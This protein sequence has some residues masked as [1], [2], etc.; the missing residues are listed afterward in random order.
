MIG[1]FAK[2]ALAGAAMGVNSLGLKKELEKKPEDR[3]TGTIVLASLG[4]A[5]GVALLALVMVNVGDD[6]GNK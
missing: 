5:S 4:L 2:C 3:S 1:F 6:N